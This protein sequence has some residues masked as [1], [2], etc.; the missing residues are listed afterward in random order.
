MYHT[1]LPFRLATTIAVVFLCVSA[2]CTAIAPIAI[3][4]RGYR[5]APE[6][7][8]A[9]SEPVEI[10]KPQP[11]IDSIGWVLGI[12]DKILLWD[13]RVSQHR[14]SEPTLLTAADYIEQNNLPHVKV[15]ANQY[16][17][18]DDLKRLPKNKTVGWPYRYTFGVLSVAGEAIIPGRLLGGDHF[19]PYTQ[20]VH[21]YSD[22][23]AIA[24]HE[25]GHAKDFTRRKWQGT[26]ALAYSVVPLWHE[27]NAS[28]DAMAY[29]EQRNDVEGIAEAN[30]TL[31]PA[32]GTYV[33]GAIGDFVPDYALPIYVGAVVAGHINGRLLNRKLVNRPAKH[34]YAN[35]D[36]KMPAKTAISLVSVR[37]DESMRTGFDWVSPDNALIAEAT[38]IE[39]ESLLR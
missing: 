28:Q 12:P 32:Y 6:L 19:N 36:E 21:L 30:R 26:Y 16:A 17:P 38:F 4:N 18:L 25:L 14:I 8:A 3:P 13:R 29:L 34:S 39:E 7:I 9:N 10:G 33:G 27:T 24:L 5:I 2:G 23:P 22:V 31:Y 37:D 1:R 35:V 11:I 15:R 20:T